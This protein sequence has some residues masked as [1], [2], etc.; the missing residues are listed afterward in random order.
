[1][2]KYQIVQNNKSILIRSTCILRVIYH[3]YLQVFY[4]HILLW[5]EIDIDN[6]FK[7]LQI[8]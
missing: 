5:S 7:K 2:Y 4:L 6:F 8:S 3:K 1:M